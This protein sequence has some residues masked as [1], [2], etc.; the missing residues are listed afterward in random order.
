V[1][2]P[3]GGDATDERDDERR[4]EHH[5]GRRRAG[6]PGRAPLTDQQK[7]ILAVA[8]VVHAVVV[9]LTLRDLR[10]RPAGAVR[11]PKWLWGVAATLNT[12]GSAAYWLF[13]RRRRAAAPAAGG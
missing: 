4:H 1:G 8:L 9:M 12:S 2:G 7:R 10:R 6:G 13:G 3:A 5:R 11:G